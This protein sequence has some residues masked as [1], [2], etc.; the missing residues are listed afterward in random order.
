MVTYRIH[1]KRKQKAMLQE[2]ALFYRQIIRNPSRESGEVWF[3][4]QRLGI[5]RL[6]KLLKKVIGKKAG[7]AGSREMNQKLQREE[8]F[9]DLYDANVPGYR[10]V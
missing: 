7:L 1:K 9:A 4:K 3:K 6:V 10:I 8:N 2:N 5:K